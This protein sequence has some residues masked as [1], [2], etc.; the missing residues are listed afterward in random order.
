MKAAKIL[1]V[2]ITLLFIILLTACESTD[3]FKVSVG[4]EPDF[5][6]TRNGV[7]E[8]T[9]S[10]VTDFDHVYDSIDFAATNTVTN[11]QTLL[12]N[13]KPEFTFA[14]STAPYNIY[15][16]TKSA[17]RIERYAHFSAS[18]AS[19]NLSPTNKAVTLPADTQQSLILIVK[20]GVQ[21]IPVIKVG[22]TTRQMYDSPKYYYAYVVDD[23]KGA[24][25]S[26]TIGGIAI[27]NIVIGVTKG[28]VY[29]FNPIA[30][31]IK[32]SDPFNAVITL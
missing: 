21:S 12:K 8:L 15:M 5:K 14:A 4:I 13:S 24:N 2:L 23:G 29:V 16:G 6:V 11:K 22:S 25:I 1:L 26:T 28:T 20:A 3:N 19:A 27:D 31:S 7:F 17:R 9:A 18:V 30:A 32:S 10:I